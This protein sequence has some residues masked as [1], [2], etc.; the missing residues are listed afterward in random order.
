M[1]Y[2]DTLPQVYYM[3]CGNADPTTCSMNNDQALSG[4]GITL[5]MPSI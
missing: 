4:K 1:K 2:G 5:M 3:V